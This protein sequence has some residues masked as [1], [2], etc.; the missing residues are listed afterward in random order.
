[1]GVTGT[2]QTLTQFENDV[3]KNEY[4]ILKQTITPS[5]FGDSRRRFVERDDV[6]VELTIEEYYQS[7]SKKIENAI[8]KGTY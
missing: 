5:M 1:M 8:E 7:I 3:I 6:I 4:K 2:L